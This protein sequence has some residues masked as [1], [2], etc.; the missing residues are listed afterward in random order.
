MRAAL[1]G[2]IYSL[3]INIYSSH[4]TG[5]AM[6]QNNMPAFDM[7]LIHYVNRHIF[8]TIIRIMSELSG[9]IWLKQMLEELDSGVDFLGVLPETCLCCCHGSIPPPP[10]DSWTK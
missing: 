10:S 6:D 3:I 7:L 1:K 8:E 2:K 9:I 4:V 5:A